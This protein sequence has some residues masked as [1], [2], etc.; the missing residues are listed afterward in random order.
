MKLIKQNDASRDD[1]FMCDECRIV[2]GELVEFSG[3]LDNMLAY[4]GRLCINCIGKAV[5]LFACEASQ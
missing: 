1:H 5:E 2:A 3:S 4:S